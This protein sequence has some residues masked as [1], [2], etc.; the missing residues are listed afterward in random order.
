VTQDVRELRLN[1]KER[2][3][4]ARW[5][6]DAVLVLAIVWDHKLNDPIAKVGAVVVDYMYADL[7]DII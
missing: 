6:N 2:V 5:Q 7:T 3:L 4:W 1:E